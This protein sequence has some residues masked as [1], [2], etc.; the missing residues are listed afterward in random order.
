MMNCNSMLVIMM[1]V[2]TSGWACYLDNRQFF[3]VQA[4]QM[5][6]DVWRQ[7]KPVV[8]TNLVLSELTALLHSPLRIPRPQ[9]IQLLVSIRG[10]P[11]VSVEFIGFAR[12]AAAW[13]LWQSRAD[14]DWTLV[15]CASFVIMQ[16]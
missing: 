1:F 16:Q 7:A 10:N 8:T 6:H 5:M 14:K 4:A 12:D 3:H 9:Q 2:D 15:D 11:L 13:N